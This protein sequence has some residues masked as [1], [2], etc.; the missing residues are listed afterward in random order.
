MKQPNLWWTRPYGEPFLYNFT[1]TLYC[2]GKA[3]DIKTQR[4]GIR[5]IEILQEEQKDGRS[6]TF[7]GIYKFSL[8]F[9]QNKSKMF[10]LCSRGGIGIRARLRI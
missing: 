6:F 8:T 9:P 10:M 3:I 7:F 5:S 4:F 1:L 2:N